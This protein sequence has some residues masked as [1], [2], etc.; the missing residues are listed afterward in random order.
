MDKN[1]ENE[2]ETGCIYIYIYIHI[3]IYTYIHIYIYTYWLIEI[4]YELL[5]MLGLAGDH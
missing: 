1:M 2:M 3:Y 5:S 4:R